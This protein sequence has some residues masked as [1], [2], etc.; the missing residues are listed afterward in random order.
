MQSSSWYWGGDC[1]SH[2][3]VMGQ[4]DQARILGVTRMHQPCRGKATWKWVA[5]S[6]G[7]VCV[8]ATRGMVVQPAR[9]MN[10][11]Q[12]IDAWSKPSFEFGH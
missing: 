11:M 3:L 6:R 10:S 1:F 2:P 4:H 9:M 7:V 5:G 12:Y 8:S